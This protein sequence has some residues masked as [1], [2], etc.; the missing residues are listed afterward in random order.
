MLVRIRCLRCSS[1][2]RVQR[3]QRCN[4]SATTNP[5][6]QNQNL[7]QGNRFGNHSRLESQVNPALYCLLSEILTVAV[8]VSLIFFLVGAEESTV[9]NFFLFKTSSTCALQFEQRKLAGMADTRT[10]SSPMRCRPARLPTSSAHASVPGRASR[11][12][13]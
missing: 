4:H 12:S 1:Q 13:R 6:P 10:H 11:V 7:P 9:Q 3:R 8:L 5:T 2:H